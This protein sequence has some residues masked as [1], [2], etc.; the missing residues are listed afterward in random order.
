VERQRAAHGLGPV[1]SLAADVDVVLQRQE[2]A[3]AAP[4][5]RRVVDQEDP[6][7]GGAIGHGSQD[8]PTRRPNDVG[9]ST[10]HVA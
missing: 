5:D 1:L 3:Q 6:D 4:H 7:A 9:R 10:S 8:T 2:A